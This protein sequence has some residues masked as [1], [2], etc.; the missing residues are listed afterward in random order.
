MPH[1]NEFGNKLRLYLLDMGDMTH[2]EF[3]TLVPC[4]RSYISNII[5]GSQKCG[6]RMARRIEDVTNGQVSHKLAFPDKV[7]VK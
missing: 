5:N 2:E 4:A 1:S 6:F 3:A 7:V